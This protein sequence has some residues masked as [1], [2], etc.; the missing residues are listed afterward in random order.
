MPLFIAPARACEANLCNH[1]R[2]EVSSFKSAAAGIG[3][4]FITP[5]SRLAFRFLSSQRD[6]VVLFRRIDELLA[7]QHCEGTA[8]PPPGSA[9]Q[10]DVVDKAAARGDKRVGKFL[11]VL[12][13][14]RLDRS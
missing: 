13:G 1:L 3:L 14:A 9:R 12:L 10:D 8:Q 5:R 11:P 4:D 2:R 7:A 6:V